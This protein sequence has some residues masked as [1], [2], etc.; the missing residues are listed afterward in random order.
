VRFHRN[1]AAICER[2]LERE[3]KQN[4]ES[5]KEAY[6]LWNWRGGTVFVR[7]R[8]FAIVRRFFDHLF[9]YSNVFDLIDDFAC[10]KE[11]KKE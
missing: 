5:A 1:I 11:R 8:V 3:T 9:S 6:L 7:F 2:E 4:F 10:R